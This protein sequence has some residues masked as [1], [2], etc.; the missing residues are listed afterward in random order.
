MT[1]RFGMYRSEYA[2]GVRVSSYS[3]RRYYRF[4]YCEKMFTK[5]DTIRWLLDRHPCQKRLVPTNPERDFQL[6]PILRQRIRFL[7]HRNK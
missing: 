5:A 6:K 2:R 4:K 1:K 7:D 3:E